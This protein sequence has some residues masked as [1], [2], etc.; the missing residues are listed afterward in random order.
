MSMFRLATLQLCVLRQCNEPRFRRIAQLADRRTRVG[1]EEPS[2]LLVVA[3]HLSDAVRPPRVQ[4]RREPRLE[5]LHW[6]TRLEPRNA[7][8]KWHSHYR[9][10]RPLVRDLDGAD[11]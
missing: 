10:P 5:C 7:V 8:G 9:R 1:E 2:P 4:L 11:R 3:E 6:G